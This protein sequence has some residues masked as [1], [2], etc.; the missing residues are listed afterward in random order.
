MKILI[1]CTGNSC[2]SQMAEYFL[3]SFDNTM[4][5]FSAGSNP[6][7]RVNPRSITVMNEVG[8]DLSESKPKRVEI[9]TTEAFDFVITVCGN[10]RESCP[11]FQGI[12]KNRLHMGFEDPA[13]ATGTDEEVMAVYRTIRDQIKDKFYQF[14]LKIKS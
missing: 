12:V 14:Y 5:V 1:V 13:I 8:I 10:A 2:R 3:K 11:V 7:K 9:F 6:E 4:E